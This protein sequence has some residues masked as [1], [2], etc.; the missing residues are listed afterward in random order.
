MASAVPRRSTTAARPAHPMATSMTPLRQARPKVSETTTATSRPVAAPQPVADA[1]G[2]AVGV[3]GE[4]GR[5]ARRPTL[6]RSTPALAQTNPWRVSEIDQVAAPAEDAHRLGLD[7]A[8]PVGGVVGIDRHHAAFGLGHDLLGDHDHVAVGE[9]D[10]RGDEAGEIVAP[11]RSRPARS[12]GITLRAPGAGSVT[13][14]AGVDRVIAGAR[15]ASRRRRRG[16]ARP[17]RR[18]RSAV[19]MTVGA[20]T[21][22]TP[23]PRPSAA[24]AASASS[25]TR[26]PTNVGVQA[27]HADHGGLVAQLGHESRS[28]GPFRA[29]PA[30]MGETATTSVAPAVAG[31]S[32]MPGTASIGTDRHDGVGRAH[33]DDL[34]LVDGVEHAGAGA[35]R[36]RHPRT[37]PSARPRRVGGRR[38]TPGTRPRAR[39]RASG[40]C[41][42]GRRTWGGAGPR[43]PRAAVISAVT[44]DSVAPSA[45][46]WVR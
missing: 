33:H 20:T 12:T 19:C 27:G 43:R 37:G 21:Q 6:E 30:T 2:R 8:E 46:R 7:D 41:A 45:R 40:A 4:Q 15:A 29:A 36:A 26:V 39:R 25:T 9:F 16:G 14:P 28:A 38:S 3:V 34:G 44:S 1:P 10:A 24:R 23:Q 42:R 32:A 11:A 22:R 5:P 35:G 18:R 31:P 17:A 13:R